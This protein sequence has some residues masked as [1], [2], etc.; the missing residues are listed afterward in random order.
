VT[1]IVTSSNTK[2]PI[3][4]NFFPDDFIGKIPADISV[5]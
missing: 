4:K 1:G 3:K 2:M 5:M